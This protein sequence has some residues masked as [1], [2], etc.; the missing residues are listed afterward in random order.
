METD[1]KD[2]KLDRLFTAARKAELYEANR[3]YGF[4]TR[5]MEKI[6]AQRERQAP[7]PLFAWRL[8]PVFVS[9]VLLL[10]IWIYTS[11]SQHMT[12][13]SAVADIGN[14]ESMLVAYLTGE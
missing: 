10:G 8:I 1:P 3:E 7:F 5:V 6:R 9:I 13:L 2:S 12:D 11:R 4:E 14:E